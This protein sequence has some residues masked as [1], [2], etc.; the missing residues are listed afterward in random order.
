MERNSYTLKEKKELKEF[1]F[2]LTDYKKINQFLKEHPNLIFTK[3]EELAL[4]V[5]S[6]DIVHYSNDMDFFDI[7]ITHL[8]KLQSVNGDFDLRGTLIPFFVNLKIV[9]GSLNLFNTQIKS[10]GVLKEVGENLNLAN[11]LI[12]SLEDVKCSGG[13]L[14]LQNTPVKSLGKLK[15]VK[16][17]LDILKSVGGFLDLRDTQIESVGKN[18]KHVGKDLYL[19]KK[20][21]KEEL[22]KS[23]VVK[24][25]TIVQ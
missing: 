2:S 6:G 1:V 7:P 3:K 15:T 9:D 18:L 17:S 22:S 19:N 8:G 5:I 13:N 25:R 24:G 16:K 12:E 14:W 21:K 11:T 4:E 20:I 10:L 23:L